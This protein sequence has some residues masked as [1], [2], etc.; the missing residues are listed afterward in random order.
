MESKGTFNG[1]AVAANIKTHCF[2]LPFILFKVSLQTEEYKR[3]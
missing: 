1:R 2:I 3:L